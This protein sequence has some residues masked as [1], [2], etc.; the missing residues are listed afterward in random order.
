LGKKVVLHV[1]KPNTQAWEE[2]DLEKYPAGV[3]CS[4]PSEDVTV[5]GEFPLR[6]Y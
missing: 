2:L 3:A 6:A 4:E 1:R 5:I